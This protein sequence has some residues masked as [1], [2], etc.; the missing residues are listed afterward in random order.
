MISKANLYNTRFVESFYQ[1]LV[2]YLGIVKEK[3][4]QKKK[5]QLNFEE[6][7]AVEK[8]DSQMGISFRILFF[9][10]KHRDNQIHGTTNL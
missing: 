8:D 10:R 6:I 9:F 4:E 1:S 5:K 2:A 3:K 7:H